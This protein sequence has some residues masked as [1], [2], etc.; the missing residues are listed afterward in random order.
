MAFTE[1]A[2]VLEDDPN[3]AE[4]GEK[5]IQLE[6]DR[7]A[8]A[9][10]ALAGGAFDRQQVAAMLVIAEANA[11]R[12][13]ARVLWLAKWIRAN[14]APGGIW[15]DRRLVLF[16]EYED[17]RRWLQRC[18]AEE[19]DDLAA[20]DRIAA[21]TGSTPLDRRED[22]KRRFNSDPGRD[23]LRILICTDAARE[24]INLQARCYDLI[25][26]DLPWNPARLEQRN[27]RIDRKLQPA[28]QVFCRY[29]LYTQREEDVVLDA[30]VR[31]T[32]LIRVQL[33]S[34]GQIIGDRLGNLLAR[35][36]IVRASS[37]A[38][39]IAADREDSLTR[40]A[41]AEM[42]DET[43]SRLARQAREL[44]DLRT[45]LERS[46]ERVGVD[47][48]QLRAVVGVALSRAD[49][50]LD[51]SHA[52][53]VEGTELFRL[54]PTLP[55]FSTGSW[56]EALDDLRVRRRGRSERLKDWRATAPLRAICFKPAIT[57][58][59]ADAEDPATA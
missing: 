3:T 32:E 43:K 45:A 17:T 46:R 10:A 38:R 58:G 20:E 22:L 37:L 25:H 57:L 49:A 1:G 28:K 54:D 9:A 4:A 6:E 53:D 50:S 35:N 34:A 7:N 15:N 47:V 33:G 31:K 24:G 51:K 52:G 55:A 18:L 23:K 39:E 27:G 2:P 13:D 11:H 19:L 14:C 40:T 44:D 29:F 41:V 8:E 56:P 16:T 26:I 36:G 12:L 30:L 48:G 59:G 42:D 5:A 21:F